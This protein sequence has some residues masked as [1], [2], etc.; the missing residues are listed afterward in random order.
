MRCQE[1]VYGAIVVHSSSST[2]SNS[3]TYENFNEDG[4]GA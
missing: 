4:A 2:D 3:L 1:S